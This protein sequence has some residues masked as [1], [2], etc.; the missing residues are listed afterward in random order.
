MDDML[1]LERVVEIL[2]TKPTVADKEGAAE[3]QVK[4]GSISFENVSAAYDPRQET[5]KKVSFVAKP[6]EKMALVGE[7]GAGKSTILKLLLRLYDITAGSIKIDGQDI[8]DV[9]IASLRARIGVVPQVC[10]LNAKILCAC[11]LYISE[12]RPFQ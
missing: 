7:S 4:S 6:G 3:L 11:R 8:R 10:L 1:N 5:L 2:E 12:S 9:T